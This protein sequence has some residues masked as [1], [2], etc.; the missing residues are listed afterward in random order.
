MKFFKSV[1][2]NFKSV[3][4]S[5]NF[6]KVSPVEK[7]TQNALIPSLVCVFEAQ[8]I[9]KCREALLF[10]SMNS[11]DIT[12]SPHKLF[13]GKKSCQ[14]FLDGFKSNFCFQKI[15]KVRIFYHFRSFEILKN[16][17]MC[18][19]WRRKSFLRVVKLCFLVL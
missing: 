9:S 13:G 6:S 11:S 2:S 14:K 18:A 5:C 7:T 3:P 17:M 16:A 15:R 8:N 1:P 12:L 19:F 4:G 10:G